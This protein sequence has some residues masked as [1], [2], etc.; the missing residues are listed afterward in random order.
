M[1]LLFNSASQS[2]LSTQSVMCG[3]NLVVQ[4]KMYGDG[5][6][7]HSSSVKVDDDGEEYE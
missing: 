5:V 7:P 1:F 6:S 3:H 2:L 4:G